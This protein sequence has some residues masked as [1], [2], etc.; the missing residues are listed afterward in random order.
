MEINN[1]KRNNID[2][3]VEKLYVSKPNFTDYETLMA[4]KTDI[5]NSQSKIDNNSLYTNDCAL[6]KTHHEKPPFNQDYKKPKPIKKYKTPEISVTYPPR[7]SEQPKQPPMVSKCRSSPFQRYNPL[8]EHFQIDTNT[9]RMGNVSIS[10]ND[11]PFELFQEDNKGREE[12]FYDSV[13]NINES[14]ILS[15]VYF[16][17]KNIDIIQNKIKLGVFE[18]SKKK[19][20]IGKQSDSELKII[21]RSIYLQYSK[22]VDCKIQEQI[23]QL[24]QMVLNYSID[25]IMTNAV[26]Y[27]NYINDIKA[28]MNVF[29]NPINTGVQKSLMPNPFFT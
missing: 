13:S 15:K 28:P 16:S 22:N 26:G 3:K 9:G 25:N 21:M 23:K 2:N 6:F 10:N 14:T 11:N 19:I 18:K 8:E 29:E 1:F 24:N 20:L 17:R 7:T 4:T 12:N 5:D 27:I